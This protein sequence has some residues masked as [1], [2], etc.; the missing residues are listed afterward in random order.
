MH[1][2]RIQSDGTGETTVIT[3]ERGETLKCLKVEVEL[4]VG[5]ANEAVI[6]VLIPIVDTHADVSKT[7]FVCALCGDRMTHL[8]DKSEV[9]FINK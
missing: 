9:R 2:I 1:Q 7:V 5:H 4:S 3:T 6:T 8:C